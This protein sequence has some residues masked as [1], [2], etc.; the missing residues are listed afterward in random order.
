MQKPSI[1]ISNNPRIP[2][3]LPDKTYLHILQIARDYIHQG[4]SLITH[5]LSGSIK[6][7]ET[8]YKTILI[9]HTANGLDLA[10][11]EII[12]N[13]LAAYHHFAAIGLPDFSSY[14]PHTLAEFMEIDKNLIRRYDQS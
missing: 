8:P 13:S 4:H 9:S 10:S 12:E 3:H 14:P 5:P 1:T 7:N 2:D 6:P 11:L